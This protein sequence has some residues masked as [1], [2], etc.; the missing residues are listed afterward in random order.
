MLMPT[1]LSAPI[2][3]EAEEALYWQLSQDSACQTRNGS[4]NFVAMAG[5]FNQ[6]WGAQ[7]R[8]IYE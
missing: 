5:K 2:R 6:H 1:D 7:V 4:P 3:T 8:C